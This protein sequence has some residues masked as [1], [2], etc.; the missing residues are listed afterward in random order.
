MVVVKALVAS[1]PKGASKPSGSN[2]ASRKKAFDKVC[3][4]FYDYSDIS[5]E[6]LDFLVSNLP[7]KPTSKFVEFGGCL[8][9]LYLAFHSL[10]AKS[11]GL[12]SNDSRLDVVSDYESK[13]AKQVPGLFSVDSTSSED[14]HL[15]RADVVF[16]NNAVLG[17]AYIA[18]HQ[19]F[20][21]ENLADD[22]TLVLTSNPWP[23]ASA[24][25]PAPFRLLKALKNPDADVGN[26][27][28]NLFFFGAQ[29]DDSASSAPSV[30]SKVPAPRGRRHTDIYV[31]PI[32]EASTTPT[33]ATAK[34]ASRPSLAPSAKVEKPSTSIENDDMDLGGRKRSAK[35]SREEAAPTPPP[36]NVARAPK[37]SAASKEESDEEAVFAPTQAKRKAV[38][39]KKIPS[40][41]K[42]QDDSDA[43]YSGSASSE[44]SEREVAPKAAKATATP[45]AAGRVAH[46]QRL[47][48]AGAASA[49]TT[50]T[51]RGRRARV[52][53]PEEAPASARK[54]RARAPINSPIG[55][56]AVESSSA[57]PS[58]AKKTRAKAAATLAPAEDPQIVTGKRASPFRNQ[59]AR[60]SAVSATELASPSRP[61]RT[62]HAS[63]NTSVNGAVAKN[64]APKSVSAKKA[65]AARLTAKRAMVVDE[66][67]HS[68]SDASTMD[69]EAT[70]TD[71]STTS[72]AAMD[73]STEPETRSS[74][75]FSWLFGG[76]RRN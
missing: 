4:D 2:L 13:L 49:P 12:E 17:A 44:Y 50:P 75:W 71:V 26:G 5:S 21:Q 40:R 3:V 43:D 18:D 22:C 10:I 63:N 65:S 20:L 42:R 48:A 11:H 61:K 8:T 46:L 39:S 14:T 59:S 64:S 38:A 1:P 74:G 51:D 69:A 57:A 66:D 72:A 47:I 25:R 28:M 67:P 35:R 70:S 55:R 15:S 9:A 24:A 33:R 52:E 58:S 41:A 60:A 68:A 27:S 73:V 7:L 19:A 37:R 34:R 23:R 56:N 32:K 54:A 6:G 31:P 16:I 29:T 76:W 30:A 62:S 45:K 53:E 36:K